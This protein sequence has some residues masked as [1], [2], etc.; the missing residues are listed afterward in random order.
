MPVLEPSEDY[1]GDCAMP[2]SDGC[3]WDESRQRFRL[4]Y[5]AG[6]GGSTAL[7]E[8]RDG[9]AWDKRGLVDPAPRDSST[10]WPDG[11]GWL[12]A[13]YR[14]QH[15][16]E[17]QRSPDGL[18]WT[19]VGV[20]PPCDDRSTIFR[21]REHWYLSARIGSKHRAREYWRSEDLARWTR[22]PSDLEDV[23]IWDAA[24]AD[25]AAV[26]LY[27]VDAA[28][29]GD[30]LLGL[31]AIWAGD[32]PGRPKRNDLAVVTSRDG[33]HWTRGPRQWMTED[34]APYPA[35]NLQSCGG[36]C[37]RLTRERLGFYVSCRTGDPRAVQRCVTGLVTIDARQVC[38]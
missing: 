11:D 5:M 30:G 14:G 19:R 25:T 3:W 9:Y 20:T 22:V 28:P 1:E 16:L 26:A 8:S 24:L 21:F 18:R 32:R 13:S 31:A 17:L 2:F 36:V 12:R 35:M 34:T 6:Y 7:A 33:A 23:D 10:V 4:W 38:V 15:A 29:F 37:V 27:N